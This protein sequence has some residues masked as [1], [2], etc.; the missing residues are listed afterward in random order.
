[1]KRLESHEA[2]RNQLDLESLEE[3]TGF[4]DKKPMVFGK[5]K[6]IKPQGKH[7]SRSENLK[8]EKSN[9][10]PCMRRSCVSACKYTCAVFKLCL[11]RYSVAGRQIRHCGKPYVFI[12]QFIF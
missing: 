3:E 8:T 7:F 4:P 12:R 5:D 9:L 6:L 1:M 11:C 10:S 2:P